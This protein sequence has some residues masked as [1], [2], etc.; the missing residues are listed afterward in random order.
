[1]K[2]QKKTF[3][4]LDVLV[5]N[6]GIYWTVPLADFTEDAYRKMFDVNVLGTLLASKASK[7][8]I[9]NLKS[10]CREVDVLRMLLADFPYPI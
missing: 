4:G 1:L 5:N 7:I 9:Q 8:R 2:K 10:V 6:A 3:G